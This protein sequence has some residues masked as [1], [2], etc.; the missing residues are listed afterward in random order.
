VEI[1]PS[2][3]R[4]LGIRHGASVRVESQ[5]GWLRASAFI[6]ACVQ[7]GQVFV[8]MHDGTTNRLT[9]AVFDPYSKQPS[10]KAC[11]VRIVCE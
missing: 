5:R 7:P 4:T 11:A 9:D 3:A 6:T 2:D 10:Y 1:N 8:P